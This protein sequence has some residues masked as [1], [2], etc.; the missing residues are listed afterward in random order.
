MGR[1]ALRPANQPANKQA[2]E[3]ARVGGPASARA[4]VRQFVALTKQKC[5][6]HRVPRIAKRLSLTFDY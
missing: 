5:N 6:T 4:R 2:S 1:T 3:Q